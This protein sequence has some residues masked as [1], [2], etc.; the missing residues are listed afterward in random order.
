MR[1][2]GLHIKIERNALYAFCVMVI[3]FIVI[4]GVIGLVTDDIQYMSVI[5]VFLVGL[6]V[7]IFHFFAQ[8]IHM[9]GHAI[10]AWASGYPK[11][12]MLFTYVFAYSLYPPDE[13]PLPDRIHI[14][15]SLGGSFAFG[16]L[17]VI[18]L[19]IW[20][21]ARSVP[22]WSIRYLTTYMLV[23]AGLLL[24]VS[25]VL[26]DGVLFIVQ[27]GWRTQPAEDTTSL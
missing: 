12:G 19:L 4:T 17:F 20:L 13:P 21:N 3:I 26:S 18:V 2:A 1:L 22:Q 25:A 15:R 27:K 24:F 11:S 14:Q 5:E 7:A 9:L 10:A 6:A 23:D 8:F 16:L